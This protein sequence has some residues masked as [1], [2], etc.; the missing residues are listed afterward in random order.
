MQSWAWAENSQ[1]ATVR[2][3]AIAARA[4][5]TK[6]YRFVRVFTFRSFGR[7]GDGEDGQKTL[8][9]DVLHGEIE[10]DSQARRGNRITRNE[11][12]RVGRRVRVCH[13]IGT[14]QGRTRASEDLWRTEEFDADPIV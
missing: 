13:A 1:L 7:R 10:I 8:R 9:C 14:W 6:C 11:R 5:T 3:I 2:A 12:A 4:W